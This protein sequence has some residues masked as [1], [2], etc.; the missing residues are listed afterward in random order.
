MDKKTK[1]FQELDSWKKAHNFV[2]EIYKLSEKFPKSE[3]FGLTSQ[4]RRAA[5]SIAAN[6]AEG[7]R[8]KGKADILRF[9]NISQ[10]SIE[11]CA[12]Y[13]ILSDDLNYISKEFFQNLS[14]KLDDARKL[15]NNYCFA[16]SSSV[17]NKF[18]N[19]VIQ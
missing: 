8:K 9:Y 15:L 6:I 10:G 16:I 2:L 17:S 18:S 4:F 13:L 1:S 19:S 11:E 3:M 5:I 12:Y 7:Y 14:I